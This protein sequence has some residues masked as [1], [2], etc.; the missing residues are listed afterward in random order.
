MP[1]APLCC[2]Q[3]RWE[4]SPQTHPRAR[5]QEGQG[6]CPPSGV[7]PEP[8]PTWNPKEREYHSTCSEREASSSPD[9]YI[10]TGCPVFLGAQLGS[11][12]EVVQ[13]C[14]QRNFSVP[15]EKLSFHPAE[16]EEEPGQARPPGVC[17][18]PQE[19]TSSASQKTPC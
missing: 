17:H 1:S 11:S 5:V 8:P 16:N 6:Q 3:G 18:F 7:T 13:G 15:G 9:H 14:M 12:G 4:R 10:L 19:W 2:L